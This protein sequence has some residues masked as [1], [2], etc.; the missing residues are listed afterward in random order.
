MRSIL[1]AGLSLSISCLVACGGETI[2][3]GQSKETSPANESSSGSSVKQPDNLPTDGP[4]VCPAF[5]A[6]CYQVK[7]TVITSEPGTD[8]FSCGAA[9]AKTELFQMFAKS[10]AEPT[11]ASYE[12]CTA[13]VAPV[14]PTC[15]E[16][17]SCQ[18]AG[19]GSRHIDVTKEVL[20]GGASFT[21]LQRRVYRDASLKEGVCYTTAKATLVPDSNCAVRAG[22]NP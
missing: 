20:L 5:R 21:Y 7:T 12:T 2:E 19:A 8:F 16:A 3:S 9:G 1:F 4:G 15:A 18:E 13:F 11:G 6:G 17:R 14:V 10:P 22:T